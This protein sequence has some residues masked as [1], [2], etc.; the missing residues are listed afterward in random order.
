MGVR[1]KG[2]ETEGSVIRMCWRS[3]KHCG[4]CVYDSVANVYLCDITWERVDLNDN[5]CRDFVEENDL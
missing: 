4:H 3:C 1:V 5:A 2:P